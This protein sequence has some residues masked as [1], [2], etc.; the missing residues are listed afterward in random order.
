MAVLHPS[1]QIL[2]SH[3][4]QSLVNLIQEKLT[5][6]NRSR[7]SCFMSIKGLPPSPLQVSEAHGLAPPSRAWIS[8]QRLEASESARHFLCPLG[9]AIVLLFR[10]DGA[11][12]PPAQG[13]GLFGRS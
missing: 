6:G 9:S 12:G 5:V 4:H 3:L 7:P 1:G 13:E 8:Q 10:Y 11:T 2:P